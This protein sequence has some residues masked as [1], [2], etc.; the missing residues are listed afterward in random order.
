MKKLASLLGICSIT[1]Y[2]HAQ[3][4]FIIDSSLNG[5][6]GSL[7]TATTGGLVWGPFPFG[8]LD[9]TVDIDLGVLWGTSRANVTTPLNIDP[10]GLNDGAYAGCGNWIAS[11]ATGETDIT[12]LGNGAIIDPNGNDYVVP[13]EAAGSTIYLLLQ[14]WTGN[15]STYNGVNF[16]GPNAGVKGETAPFAITLDTITSATPTDVHTMGALIFGPE[17][18][19]PALSALAAALALFHRRK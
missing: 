12:F 7:P 17:P 2:V 19:L 1:A 18:S 4:V 8:G 9:T 11:Q 13:G 14:G 3:G 6:D 5:G 10:L 16:T 15:S